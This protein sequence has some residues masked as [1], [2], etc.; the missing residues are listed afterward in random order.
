MLEKDKN[1]DNMNHKHIYKSVSKFYSEKVYENMDAIILVQ[2][3]EYK[4]SF[5][6]LFSND[7]NSGIKYHVYGDLSCSIKNRH[8]KSVCPYHYEL[9]FRR[10]L[11]PHRRVFTVCNCKQC[12]IVGYK[13]SEITKCQ[14]ISIPMPALKKEKDRWKFI[15][16]EVPVACECV[17]NINNF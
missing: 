1:N 11:F 4:E 5:K 17:L 2:L 16:E 12:Q 7:S 13:L 9:K 10:E 8:I 15:I 3:D 6:N 14:P